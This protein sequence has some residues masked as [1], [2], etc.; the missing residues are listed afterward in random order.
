MRN[1]IFRIVTVLVLLCP[2]IV[3]AQEVPEEESV[4]SII[5][6]T[7][8][9]KDS[10]LSFDKPVIVSGAT[11]T[12]EEGVHITLSDSFG[13]YG[14]FQIQGGRILANGTETNPIVFAPKDGTARYQIFFQ[15]SIEN[16]PSLL[17]YVHFL[18][19]GKEG[20]EAGGDFGMTPGLPTLHFFEGRLRIENSLFQGSLSSDIRA[21]YPYRWGE[22]TDTLS[23][24]NSNFSYRIPYKR[25]DNNIPI[26]NTEDFYRQANEAVLVGEGACPEGVS[27]ESIVSL[28]NNYYGDMTGPRGD[29]SNDYGNLGEGKKV[30]GMVAYSGFRQN[31]L[32]ADP[33]IVV[34]GILGSEKNGDGEWVLDPILHI[35][36]DLVASLKK[37][38]YEE[39]KNLFLFPYDWKRDNRDTANDLKQKITDIQNE[40]GSNTVDIA[41]HSMGGLVTRQYIE[42]SAYRNDIDQL[43]TLGTPHRGAPKAYLMWEGGE[44]GTDFFDSI[45]KHHFTIEAE[46]SGYSS[47]YDYIRG[48]VFS[49][50]QLLPDY[51]YLFDLGSGIMR[52]YPE[53]YS[54]NEFLENLTINVDTLNSIRILNIIGKQSIQKSIESIKLIPS[55]EIVKWGNGMPLDFYSDSP[56]NGFSF[57]FGD[58]TVPLSSA[59]ALPSD[60]EEIL[61]AEHTELPSRA[62]C[63]VFREVSGRSECKEI[64]EVNVPNIFLIKVFSPIDIQIVSPSGKRI[65]KD[66]ETGEVVN[67]INGAF[68]TGYRTDNEFV[69]I[70]NPEDGEYR[71]LTQGTGSGDYRIEATKITE[72]PDT[73]EA[74]ESTA[75][76]HGTT[77]P[78]V[79][80][81]QSITIENDTVR[82]EGEGD[83]IPPATTLSLSGTEST[84]DWFTSDV[85][86]ML[87]ATDNEN[88]SGIKHTKYSLD[89]G[90][91]WQTYE[92]PLTLSREGRHTLQYFSTD[93]AGNKETV[94]SQEI[95][96]DKTAPEAKIIFN[97]ETQTLDIVGTDTFSEPVSVSISQSVISDSD[98]ESRETFKKI[99]IPGQARDDKKRDRDDEKERMIATLTDEAGHRTDL[100]FEKKKD[101]S[102]RISIEL[103]SLVYDGVSASLPKTTLDYKWMQRLRYSTNGYALFASHIR[104]GTRKLES[105]YLPKKNE[106]LIMEKP[107]ELADLGDDDADRR[108]VR[109][110]LSG[111]IVPGLLT[112]KGSVEMVY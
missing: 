94:K 103:E 89:S 57:S 5:E 71:I 112:E 37:N 98:P 36:D 18:D 63:L 75:T 105:H 72:D 78:S 25:S 93:Q 74:K 83:T 9:T 53:N 4:V 47:L 32:L 8:W 102:G 76:L 107:R 19:G 90:A 51:D 95:K 97:S 92:H 64:I 34:P 31:D 82:G 28:R 66:F 86:I 48:A 87:S 100:S 59:E 109:K 24:I 21:E 35:Y 20:E 52:S 39:G 84:H 67:E 96:I 29:V 10:E 77:S 54:R 1:N 38:G 65:G 17:R 12:I 101:R 16:D 45:L 106:T 69:T 88:G 23:V 85:S 99:W 80:E 68:Y 60:K 108:P 70:P 56:E 13:G 49:V 73:G 50:K 41:A 14:L 61:D 6:D 46:H 15:G 3:F 110:R 27:C 26:G 55:S 7:V 40:T 111:M 104:T 91:I 42:S 43:I 22:G 58:G 44:F 2:A 79:Q 11:L 33:L 62:Q 30:L 81:E